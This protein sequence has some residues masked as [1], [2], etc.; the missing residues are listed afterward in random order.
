LVVRTVDV[1]ACLTQA[2]PTLTPVA[3]P[4][5]GSDNNAICAKGYLCFRVADANVLADNV[6][7]LQLRVA[8]DWARCKQLDVV[9][10]KE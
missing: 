3:A 4:M 2:P 8:S 6:E 9:E 5:V 10:E 7:Q 1:Q